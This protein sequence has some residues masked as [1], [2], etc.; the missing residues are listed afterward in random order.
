MRP[1]L[2]SIDKD[3]KKILTDGGMTLIEYDAAFYDEMLNVS[4]VQDL[5]KKIDA[6]TKGLGS[7]LEGALK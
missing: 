5:Y 1:Q 2:E 6:D 3:N 7:K 4:G